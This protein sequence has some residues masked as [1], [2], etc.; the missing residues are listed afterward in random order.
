[1]R[2]LRLALAAAVAC[3]AAVAWGILLPYLLG[4][5]LSPFLPP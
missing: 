2:G 3:L 4:G 1:M 5:F